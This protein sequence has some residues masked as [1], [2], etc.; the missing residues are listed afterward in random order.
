MVHLGFFAKLKKPIIVCAPMANVTDSAFRQIIARCGKPDVFWTEF[1]S[2]DGLCSSGL[3]HLEPDL[4]FTEQERPIIL[5]IFGSNPNT[6]RAAAA[7]GRERGFDGIDINM[8]C[9]DKTIEKQGAGAKLIN[10]PELA[11]EIIA[12]AKEGACD[13]PVSVKTRIGYSRDITEEWTEFLLST[14]P[15][16]I[17]FHLRTRSEMSKTKA[18]WDALKRAIAIRDSCKSKTL[19]FGNGDILNMEQARER[20]RITGADGIMVGRAIFGNPWFFSGKDRKDI[21]VS[22]RLLMMFEH[23]L[24]FEKLFSS[25]K[26]FAIMKKH[27]K[28]YTA[29]FDGSKELRV[30]LMYTSSSEAV[31]KIITDFLSS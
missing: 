20:A 28:A 18:Q 5:Q 1:I 7:L 24:L 13:L 10:N 22:T 19:I 29:D 14:E 27:F 9:P 11:K 25:S 31:R 16:L 15:A 21:S 12:A 8:G 6:I 23:T 2:A 26:N 30:Q 4:Y 3:E 17:T